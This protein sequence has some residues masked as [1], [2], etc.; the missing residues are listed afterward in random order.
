LKEWPSRIRQVP[1]EPF[2]TKSRSYLPPIINE[3]LVC[4]A[5][6]ADVFRIANMHIFCVPPKRLPRLRSPFR[7]RKSCSVQWLAE[8]ARL[9]RP[10][11]GCLHPHGHI[12]SRDGT[13]LPS[14]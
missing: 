14:L 3:L 1:S 8:R 11:R 13:V 6:C 7:G 12:V 4:L 5:D 9:P 10:T 2:A